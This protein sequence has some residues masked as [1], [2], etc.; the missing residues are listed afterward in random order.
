MIVPHD[1]AADLEHLGR[2]FI[3]PPDDL[4]PPPAPDDRR[5]SGVR[6]RDQPNE[7][8]TYR[9]L[10]E[11]RAH[12]AALRRRILISTGLWPLPERTALNAVFFGRVERE[13]YSVENIYFESRPG[14]F[15]TGNL[16]RPL[17]RAG[18]FPGVLNPHGHWDEGRLANDEMAS[19]PGRGISFAR[20]GYVAF[21]YDMVGYV[22]SRQVPHTFGGPVPE[23][24][25]FS[26]M[27]LQLWNSMRA[28]DFLVAL[29]DVDPRCLAC[30]G[31][32]AGGTQ[33]FMLTAVE[34]RVT[35]SAP[36]NMVSAHFQGGCVCENAPNL[37]IATNNVE[38]AA[39][40][41]PRPMLLVACTGD[42]TCNTPAVEYPA[43]KAI[44]R[45]FGA[46]DRLSYV[47]IDAGHNDNLA[48]R[49][50][51]YAFFNRWLQPEPEEN[52][53]R[54]QPFAAE[55]EGRL[56]VFPGSGPLPGAM[57]AGDMFR[58][59]VTR[60]GDMLARHWPRQ[61][62]DL[63]AFRAMFG[64]AL[65]DI[66]PVT[67]PDTVWSE[68]LGAVEQ[69]QYV[70]ERLL[71][72]RPGLGDQL[73]ALLFRPPG[74]T[75]GSA[76]L[77]V[78]AAGKAALVDTA[79]RRPG[80]L[81]RELLARKRAVLAIDVFL[82]G[83]Y[84]TP[85]GRAGRDQGVPFFTTYN[86]TDTAWRAHDIVTALAYLAERAPQCELALLGIGEAGLWAV[87]ARALAPMP[88]RAVIDAAAFAI[89]NDADYVERLFVPGLRAVGGLA[90]ALALAAPAPTF[91]HNAG[92]NFA[93][94]DITALYAALGCP[95]APVCQDDEASTETIVEWLLVTRIPAPR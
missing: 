62:G 68:S 88:V 30:T 78:H 39:L 23:L 94:P 36:V 44:Y 13:G 29:P 79:G 1:G 54:E 28:V 77:V 14:F 21:V 50:A 45:L 51:T 48:S 20:Q 38:I 18:P 27:G 43:I 24:W 81:I 26:V 84:H 35:V 9:S 10:E 59:H 93:I 37:R 31:A 57:G 80:P 46:E 5:V 53:P 92:G 73:P 7:L 71:L 22:D 65:A 89:D 47:Q 83:E 19:L 75:G 76:V 56:R 6:R 66:L 55:D 64:P 25:S 52:D 60:A 61:A 82:T 3:R 15:V 2:V 90:T 86:Y 85:A 32:S 95:E 67:W 8:R 70:L 58:Q 87:L 11:W 42:W 4:T 49:E 16:Y 17:G 40:M 12:A 41:A 33:T 74:W 63:A 69:E 72:G 91:I 34:D